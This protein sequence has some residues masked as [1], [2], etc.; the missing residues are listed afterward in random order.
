MDFSQSALFFT[1]PISDFALLI[2]L[3]TQFN[4]LFIRRGYRGHLENL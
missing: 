2:S 4:R 1:S 3:C